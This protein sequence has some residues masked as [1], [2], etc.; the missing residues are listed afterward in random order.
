MKNIILLLLILAVASLQATTP[1]DSIRREMQHLKGKEL[2]KA[3]NNLCALAFMQ[4]D[5]ENEAK[6]LNDYIEEA[7]RQHS[8]KE[9]TEARSALLMCYYNYDKTQLLQE[10]LPKHLDFMARHEAWNTYYNAWHLLAELYI[11]QNKYRTA[12]HEVQQLYADARRR[13]NRYGL[14]VASYGMGNA[15]QHLQNKSEAGKAYDEAIRLLSDAKD[16]TVLMCA[17]E[18]YSE[19]L[20]AGNAYEKLRTTNNGWFEKLDALKKRYAAEGYD[21]R[22]LDVKYRYYYLS[23]ARLEMETGNM[24]QARQLLRMAEKVTDGYAPIARL[25]LLRDY[26]RYYELTQEYDS[27]LKYNDE[28]LQLNLSSENHR[29]VLDAKEQRADLLTT[30]GRYKEAALLYRNFIPQRDSVLSARTADQL[31]ELSTLYKLDE[32]KL[33]N[34]LATNQ[35][36]SLS[37]ITLLLL[38]I[39]LL[40]ILYTR[41]LRRKNRV[42]YDAIQQAKKLEEANT[43]MQPVTEYV[44]EKKEQPDGESRL[45]QQLCR[46]MQQD[47]VFKD[48]Q[49][50]RESLVQMLGTN[51]VYLANAIRRYADNATVNEFINGH[52]LRHAGTLLSENPELNIS[53]VEYMSGFNSRTTF[54]RLFRDF[55]GM[56]PSEYKSIAKEKKKNLA[57]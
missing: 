8:I 7:H 11:Y 31:D 34:K 49:L 20:I 38:V 40:Y 53:E 57:N 39:V 3:H 10:Q 43:G 51:H 42:L 36:Y 27:A 55:Y 32:L 9:E 13:N 56:S 14:G 12:L 30:T 54:S 2:L 25:I 5:F 22:D 45:Y 28:R 23:M 48:P 19:V 16:M 17:Y 47:E 15:Y 50:R 26:T 1:A 6:C 24:K 29:G 46:L 44:D 33:K 35:L 18:N 21:T 37:G 4:D 41:R 52:R